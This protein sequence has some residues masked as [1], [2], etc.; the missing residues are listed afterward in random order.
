MRRGKA[1]LSRAWR[2][3]C[4]KAMRVL[5]GCKRTRPVPSPW[6]RTRLERTVRIRPALSRGR[7]VLRYLMYRTDLLL[8]QLRHQAAASGCE[9][10]T[11][12]SELNRRVTSAPVPVFVMCVPRDRRPL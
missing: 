9:W 10:V 12:S 8:R 5:P 6:A 7:V 2:T 3:G 1:G 4:M 11:R